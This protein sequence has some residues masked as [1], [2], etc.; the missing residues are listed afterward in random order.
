MTESLL[1]VVLFLAPIHAQESFSGHSAPLTF[2]WIQKLRTNQLVIR[3]G[4]NWL[5]SSYFRDCLPY[6]RIW[7]YLSFSGANLPPKTQSRRSQSQSVLFLV[8]CWPRRLP[9]PAWKALLRKDCCPKTVSWASVST[10]VYFDWDASSQ[11]VPDWVFNLSEL[12]YPSPGPV[13]DWSQS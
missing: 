12:L 13:Y 11:L 4:K 10:L 1:Q 3:S 7:S 9:S 2:H 8:A 5:C 6:L